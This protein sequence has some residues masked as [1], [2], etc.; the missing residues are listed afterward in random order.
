MNEAASAIGRFEKRIDQTLDY[1]SE[2]LLAVT[3]K[4]RQA[5]LETMLAEQS[6]MIMAVSWEAFIHD[7]L[8][9]YVG[10]NPSVFKQDLQVRVSRTVQDKYGDAVR[11]VKFRVPK[12]PSRSQLIG[13]IDPRGWNITANSAEDL[14]K[15]ANQLLPAADAKKFSLDADDGA[16]VDFLIALRNYLGHRSKASRAEVSRLVKAIQRAGQNGPLAGHLT[17][18]GAFLKDKIAGNDTRSHFIGR[19][20]KQVAQKLR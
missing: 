15:R 11:W 6:A 13:V 16:F 7:L 10:T 9:A 19:R 20:L 14:S 4:R 3:G 18:V 5:A 12:T 2:L 1:Y 17:S 8:I